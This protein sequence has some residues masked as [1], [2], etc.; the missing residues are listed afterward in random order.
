MP[1]IIA[2]WEVAKEFIQDEVQE[3]AV[4]CEL[5]DLL[6]HQKKRAAMQLYLTDVR[7]RLRGEET[8]TEGLHAADRVAQMALELA[9]Y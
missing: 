7:N 4:A 5:A 6:F 9:S 2:G 1:N 3:E 8:L